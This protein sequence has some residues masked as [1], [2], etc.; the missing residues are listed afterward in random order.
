M[1]AEVTCCHSVNKS[2]LLICSPIFAA[3]QLDK[4]LLNSIYSTNVEVIEFALGSIKKNISFSNFYLFQVQQVKT[5]VR[6]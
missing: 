6:I 1:K 4:F 5:N 3:R 2:V